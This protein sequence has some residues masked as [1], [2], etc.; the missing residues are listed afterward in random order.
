MGW[1]TAAPA[2]A[3][4]PPT[5]CGMF[6]GGRVPAPTLRGLL[7]PPVG[8]PLGCGFQ[9]LPWGDQSLISSLEM[10]TGPCCGPRKRPPSPHGLV[11]AAWSSPLPLTHSAPPLR[12][13]LPSP[14]G[15]VCPQQRRWRWVGGGGSIIYSLTR[16]RVAPPLRQEVPGNAEK[17]TIS[18]SYEAPTRFQAPARRWRG[19]IHSFDKF[20]LCT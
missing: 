6:G 3:L 1:W 14:R 7:D 17:S 18:S 12:D 19:H 10:R 11:G 15:T 8:L 2:A 4:S 5:L 20:L 9:L 16:P 13:V